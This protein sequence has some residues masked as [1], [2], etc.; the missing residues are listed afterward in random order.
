MKMP[1][2]I[3]VHFKSVDFIKLLLGTATVTIPIALTPVRYADAANTSP[4]I[5]YCYQA[6]ID[7]VGGCGS[8]SGIWPEV[9]MCVVFRRAGRDQF[10]VDVQ[11]L[12]Q[13]VKQVSS[14][15]AEYCE[16]CR[17]RFS[18]VLRCYYSR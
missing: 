15:D 7:I 14:D 18:D 6:A 5:G 17:D 4:Y 10:K 1:N 11:L 2:N 16:A 12:Q 13:Y 9:A 8:C 3:G